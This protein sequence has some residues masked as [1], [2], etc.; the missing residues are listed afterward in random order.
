MSSIPIMASPHRE[1]DLLRIAN[2]AANAIIAQQADEMAGLQRTIDRLEAALRSI[3][4]HDSG[5]WA[6]GHHR[7]DAIECAYQ[8]VLG[9]AFKALNPPPS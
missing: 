1:I 4:D 6:A 5:A 3:A 9:I 7:S 2:E 8:A